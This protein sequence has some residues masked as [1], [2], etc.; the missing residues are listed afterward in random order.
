MEKKSNH[1]VNVVRLGEPRIHTNADS[2]EIFDIEGYQCVVRK[3]EFMSGG[4]AIYIQPDSVVPQT[5]SFRFIWEGQKGLDGL[6]P[7]RRRRIKA[8][9]LRK[10]WSE[11]L[12]MPITIL[13]SNGG[14]LKLGSISPCEGCEKGTIESW[15]YQDG[16]DVSDIL[17]ITHYDPDGETDTVASM[18]RAPRRKYPKSLKGWFYFILYR[19]GFVNKNVCRA[20]AYDV[21]LPVPI[22][23]VEALKNYLHAFKEGEQVIGS[24]KIH[25]SNARYLFFEDKF[26]AG[27][28]CQWKL[29]GEGIWWKVVEKFPWIKEWCQMNPGATLYGEVVPTQ[30]GF[31]YGCQQSKEF[32]QGTVNFFAYAIHTTDGRW[33]TPF[34]PS[35][36]GTGIPFE[37]IVPVLYS[38]PFDLAAIKKVADGPSMVPGAN[39]IREGIVVVPVEERNVFRLGRLIL[40]LVS[41]E[42]LQ[43]DE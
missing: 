32:P 7:E 4:Q 30:K 24:E 5:E 23:E 1:R 20:M 8:K 39:H 27:S 3:G 13:P 6:V 10:E 2:L 38:G 12:L 15:F 25:G 29:E 16:E 28:H 31:T 22:F 40:K 37:N 9:R 19:L 33:V 26:Y 11:G 42:F 41:N 21:Q 43:K 17:G 14:H 35:F 18:T 36:Y 34:T